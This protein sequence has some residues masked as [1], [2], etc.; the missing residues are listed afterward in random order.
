MFLVGEE[1]KMLTRWLEEL[2]YKCFDFAVKVEWIYIEMRMMFKRVKE[3]I[4]RDEYSEEIDI[5]KD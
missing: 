3:E 1:R 2:A 5:Y 4:I